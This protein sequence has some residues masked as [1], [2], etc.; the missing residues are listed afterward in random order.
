MRVRMSVCVCL[1]VC[2]RHIHIVDTQPVDSYVC[3][4]FSL[5]QKRAVFL[6]ECQTN[7]RMSTSPCSTPPPSLSHSVYLFHSVCALCALTACVCVCGCVGWGCVWNFIISFIP[8]FALLYFKLFA[9]LE[10]VAI[11]VHSICESVCVSV[12]AC[13]C[14]WLLDSNIIP[15][16]VCLLMCNLHLPKCFTSETTRRQEFNKTRAKNVFQPTVTAIH[17][18]IPLVFIRNLFI[19]S[20]TQ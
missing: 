13:V 12:S 19:S 8:F 1:C 5:V 17:S 2:V 20:S 6:P 11:N 9:W 4:I 10:G 7:R 3:N 14:G 18:Y 16:F 15:A